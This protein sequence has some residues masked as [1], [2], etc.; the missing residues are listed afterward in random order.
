[1][2]HFLL[3]V[4]LIATALLKQGL[5]QP[6][7]LLSRFQQPLCLPVQLL[8]VLSQQGTDLFDGLAGGLHL[9]VFVQPMD[10]ALRA[11]GSAAGEAKVGEL[12]FGVVATGVL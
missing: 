5:C 3:D 11:D 9:V 1:M 10:G 2:G 6:L 7:S 12:L 4:F 8:L